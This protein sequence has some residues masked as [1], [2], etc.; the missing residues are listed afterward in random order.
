MEHL[1]SNL[2]QV[3]GIELKKNSQKKKIVRSIFFNGSV[4]NSALSAEL[5]LSAP[6]INSL[7]QELIAEGVVEEL[8]QGDSSGGRRPLI[9]GLAE[10][11]FYVAGIT[12]NVNYSVISVF[13]ARNAEISGPHYIPEKMQN[14]FSLF[15]RIQTQLV[16]ILQ[17]CIP[18]RDKVIAVGIEMPGLVNQGDSVNLSYFPEIANLN[19]KIGK[20]FGL[21]VF[22]DNDARMRTFAEHHFGLAKG[23][24]NVLMVLIDWGIGMGIIIDGK[25]Y[26]GKSGFSGEFGHI[27]LVENGSLCVCGKIGCLESVASAQ[28]ITRQAR[29]GVIEG[30]SSLIPG[31]TG[32][33]PEKIDPDTVI[34]AALCGDQF[35]ISILS[36]AGF[37]L[38]RGIANLIQLFNPELVII[39]G[40]MAEAA[41]FMNAP[42]EQ[43]IYT[44][45][46]TDISNDTV[47]QFSGLGAKAGTIGAAAFAVDKLAETNH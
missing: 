43:A 5:K 20:I 22:I 18:C 47:I 7:V 40:K 3:Q 23:R 46:N 33:N 34:Q 14:D 38:G 35:S 24:K 31:L 41:P 2:R 15:G 32:N 8:G 6:T 11:A 12:I 45:S 27:P 9:Y 36:N 26:T 10:D 30:V 16:K 25:P 13:N 19:L 17:A 28:A 4:S 42:I 37:W 44:Y 29:E 1:W 39:G 21:P